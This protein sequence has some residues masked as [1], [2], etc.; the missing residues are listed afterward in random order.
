MGANDVQKPERLVK[1]MGIPPSDIAEE[2]SRMH[3]R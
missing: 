1:A 3:S 2:G